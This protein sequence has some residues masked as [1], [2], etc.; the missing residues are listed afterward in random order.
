M[1]WATAVPETVYSSG[2]PRFRIDYQQRRFAKKF[3]AGPQR[4]GFT[5]DGRIDRDRVVKTHVADLGRTPS[6]I[7]HV[8]PLQI[9]VG[10]LVR[11]DHVRRSSHIRQGTEEGDTPPEAD[12]QEHG[13]RP[14]SHQRADK[15]RYVVCVTHREL[16][17]RDDYRVVGWATGCAVES[18]SV[19]VDE[20][21][22]TLL[23]SIV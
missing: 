11:H 5:P 9:Q 2:P 13:L 4:V 19:T 17:A 22:L 20:R 1:T 12:R 6:D 23:H 10:H 8:G 15:R 21:V 14:A 3:R 16:R 18:R 7:Q